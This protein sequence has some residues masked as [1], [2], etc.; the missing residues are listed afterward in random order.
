MSLAATGRRIFGLTCL[1]LILLV[2]PATANEIVFDQQEIA[3]LFA[4][5]EAI[6]S[7]IRDVTTTQKSLPEFEVEKIQSYSLIGTSL[8]AIQ[9]CLNTVLMVAAL[10]SKMEIPADQIRLLNVLRGELLPN[11]KAYIT[12]KQKAI[13]DIARAHVS[14]DKFALYSGRATNIIEGHTVPLLEKLYQRLVSVQK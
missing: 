1:F 6:H 3:Q 2:S 13:V 7:L 14:D 5:N 10:L 12:A 11:S 4:V 8:E 9:E